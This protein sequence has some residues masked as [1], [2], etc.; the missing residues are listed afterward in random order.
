[1]YEEENL[2]EEKSDD[3]TCK[4]CGLRQYGNICA[5]CETPI[6]EEEEDLDKKKE[7]EWDEYDYRER[8]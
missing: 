6:E 5:N 1:M 4:L 8:R 7:D 2:E 3:K